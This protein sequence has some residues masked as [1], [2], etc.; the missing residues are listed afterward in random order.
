M[1]EY[2]EFELQK[3]WFWNWKNNW[4]LCKLWFSLSL[5]LFFL[6]FELN[7]IPNVFFLIWKWHFNSYI[8]MLKIFWIYCA[9]WISGYSIYLFVKNSILICLWVCVSVYVFQERELFDKLFWLMSTIRKKNPIIMIS[10]FS[11]KF[12][13]LSSVLLLLTF[14]TEAHFHT[15]RLHDDLFSDCKFF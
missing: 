6:E 5:D 1:N 4:F 11:I 9:S 13:L 12:F 2:I 7:K 10:R 14:T 8:R 15:K 3:G